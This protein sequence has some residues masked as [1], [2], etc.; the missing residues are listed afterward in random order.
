MP[1]PPGSVPT[2]G[3]TTYPGDSKSNDLVK[4]VG[5]STAVAL[6][7]VEAPA[8]SPDTINDIKPGSQAAV[9]ATNPNAKAVKAP[10]DKADDS[11]SKH[12]KKKGIGKL[13]PF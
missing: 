2:N 1:R 5:G 6:P 3:S 4:P 13:N 12:K 10:Y 9:P 8:D 7:P 11:S